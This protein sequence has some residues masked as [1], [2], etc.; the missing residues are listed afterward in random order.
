MNSNVYLGAMR[1][2][3]ILLCLLLLGSDSIVLIDIG[4]LPGCGTDA[5]QL[6]C[7]CV[8]SCLR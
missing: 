3:A 4:H 8:P 7:E 6:R 1:L 5:T 2:V